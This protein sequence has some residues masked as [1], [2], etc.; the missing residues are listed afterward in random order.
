MK[1]FALILTTLLVWAPL[2][3]ADNIGTF[4][5][6]MA[7]AHATGKGQTTVSGTFGFTDVTTY[8][9]SLGYG[10]TDKMDGRIR[11]GAIDESGFETALV[12]GGDLRWQLWNQNEMTGARPKPFDLSVGGFMEWSKWNAQEFAPFTT[13][14][15]MS[16]FELGFQISGSHTYVMSNGSTLTPYGRVNLRHEN[17]SITMEDSQFPGEMSASDS[18][19][20]AGVNMGLAWGVTEQFA[21][22]GELQL[23][24][25][26]GL[27][28]GLDYRP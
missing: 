8:G 4:F 20:A 16:V 14:M 26:D 21:L 5:G 7:T 3:S 17:A 10:F 1:A 15:S 23:D 6:S 22:M 19:I 28:L 9:G 24:G 18:Q 12:L 25:N 27:F 13:S 11:I 2:A